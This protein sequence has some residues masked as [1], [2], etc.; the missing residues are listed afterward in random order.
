MVVLLI[1]N[2][3]PSMGYRYVQ[4]EESEEHM[5]GVTGV[6]NQEII[7]WEEAMSSTGI[8]ISYA[9][10]AGFS[11]RG[12]EVYKEGEEGAILSS[13]IDEDLE[14]G[15]ITVLDAG[16]KN[17]IYRIVFKGT[18][19]VD[20]VDT[21]V[22]E[23]IS[24]KVCSQSPEYQLTKS[25][26]TDV[27]KE[28]VTITYQAEKDMVYNKAYRTVYRV[29]AGGNKSVVEGK[30]GEITLEARGE[31]N[32]A[33]EETFSANEN[34]TIAYE[35]YY[36]L[37]DEMGQAVDST[38]KTMSFV[39]DKKAPEMRIQHNVS[40]S[41]LPQESVT[42]Q[43]TVQEDYYKTE[44]SFKFI[45]R[46]E[47]ID[48]TVDTKEHVF[49]QNHW[50]TTQAITFSEEGKYF[51]K[52]VAVDKA[53]NTVVTD[54]LEFIID[55]SAPV[56]TVTETGNGVD[57]I[58]Q[59]MTLD[60]DVFDI[61]GSDEDYEVKVNGRPARLTWV[62][63]QD[64]YTLSTS[65]TFGKRKDYSAET[66][67]EIVIKAKD[68]SNHEAAQVVKRFVIDYTAP[69]YTTVKV[70]S[71]KNNNATTVSLNQED[72]CYYISGNGR[73]SAIIH[74][75]NPGNGA[76]ASVE[77][78]KDGASFIQDTIPLDRKDTP[79]YTSVLFE[80]EG[81]YLA[82]IES[83]DVAGNRSSY[84]TKEMIVDHTAPV[85]DIKNV[86]GM[87]AVEVIENKVYG[88]G[89]KLRF[90]ATDKNHAPDQYMIRVE[91]RKGFQRDVYTYYGEDLN[92]KSSGDRIWTDKSFVEDGQYSITFYGK[93]KA[94]NGIIHTDYKKVSFVIDQTAPTIRQISDLISN[95]YYNTNKKFK[96]LVEES[97]YENAVVK[98]NV[99]RT[100]DGTVFTDVDKELS[101]ESAR[102]EFEYLCN[103]EG[104][105]RIS[106]RV[107]DT[108]GNEDTYQ[109]RFVIDKT[110]PELSIS[111]VQ[112]GGKTKEPVWL[113][114]GVKDRNHDF[115]SYKIMVTRTNRDGEEISRVIDDA[116]AWKNNGYEINQQN[117][118]LT[119]RGLGYK[120][121]GNY[122]VLFEGIDKA[123]N[124]AV[125]KRLTFTIDKTAP[126]I[127]DVTYTN[128][129]GVIEQ[130]YGNIYSNRT[131][132]LEF[133][134]W[135]SVAG[136][137]RNRIY[138]TI[139]DATEK[140]ELSRLFIARKGL[141]RSYYVYIPSDLGVRELDSKI[142]IWAN[143][144][145]G[146]ESHHVTNRIVYNTEKPQIHME[147]D[148]D[149]T[150]WVNQDVTFHTTVRDSK[151]GIQEITYSI[152]GEIVKQVTFD[153]VV[154]DYSYD[155]VATKNAD[156]VSGYAV[157]VEV[158]NN[159][160]LTAK[161]TRQV[162]IDKQAPKVELTGVTNE[163]HYNTNQT[164]HTKVS[165][166]SYKNTK[167][168]YYVT[169]TLDGVEH[170]VPLEDF[171]PQTYTDD[172]DH[173]MM[174]EGAY[175]MHAVTI[176]GAGNKT[177]SNELIFIIDKT[178]PKLS[179]TGVGSGSMNGSAVTLHFACEESFYETNQVSIQVEKTIDGATTTQ[180]LGGFPKNG[181]QSSMN[182]SFVLDGTYR[183]TFEARDKAGNVA[184]IQEVTF[185]VD[186]TIPEVDIRGTDNYEMWDEGATLQFV[187]TDSYYADNKVVI[188]GTRQDIDG[189]V[190]PVVVS[191]FVIT[192]K[193]STL[194]Q[195][196]SEDGIYTFVL[197][198]RDKAGNEQSKEIH[199][200]IDKTKPEIRGVSQYNG[201]YYQAFRLAQDLGEIFKDLTVISFK[202][203]L[204][205]IEYN[206]VDEIT[207]E[208]KYNL[209]V[210]V[211]DELGHINETNIEF[212]I[213]HT[214]PKIIFTGAPDGG[215]VY[216]A[217]T[218]TFALINSEDYITGIRINGTDYGTDLRSFDYTEYGSYHIEVDC[219]DEAGNKVTRTLYFVYNNPNVI[220]ILIGV[221][222]LFAICM[223]A[224]LIIQRKRRKGQS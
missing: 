188:E 160:G 136:V 200:T 53:G 203:F 129:N 23:T 170:T 192:G 31:Y 114:F 163:V 94:G 182:H 223:V 137:D 128:T 124:E 166:V 21:V 152:D 97:D 83:K 190:E 39:I 76:E 150:T 109:I 13:S 122:E 86:N 220:P 173:T 96:Y 143:D 207:E 189:H 11:K 16:D 65:I 85:F 102:Q 87:T 103:K 193:T 167:T 92:W 6:S 12:Y 139:G 222:G 63:G 64:E 71:V 158:T 41:N 59:D 204:N 100:L 219:C 224:F 22:E 2:L 171:V 210:E 121:E 34:E 106:V 82:T 52:A 35:I 48:G 130:K 181:K 185:S 120:E 50:Q 47:A 184:Q 79:Y 211:E 8:V 27:T 1:M 131:I 14:S 104:I 15:E 214:A 132:L 172:C 66:E 10:E 213:D 159:S 110:K 58:H 75:E 36:V 157:T 28:D 146:N 198:A 74:E 177:V 140:T 202:M 77:V 29:D 18:K 101:M 147:S 95:E 187:V 183:V 4:A 217:G 91:H 117:V 215:D 5:V 9:F 191:P 32:L 133:N 195:T 164:I 17:N 175:K 149:Y 45:V 54:I 19:E 169:R 127:S 46:K 40:S 62:K 201:G 115:S 161:A 60:I 84:T 107:K 135:D 134:V 180:E 69:A 119:E 7:T 89:L 138:V 26:D 20:G 51:V 37:K 156:K 70:E 176:D 199:F 197:S 178:A 90:Y 142:T 33:V 25:V 61:C 118:Y 151:S 88:A 49:G 99:Q 113:T 42:Y 209:Y 162:Y 56:V 73:L 43:V 98:L 123:T 216:E 111:G 221:F 68:Q 93:D 81:T 196:F 179:I 116:S 3:C 206:G 194:S 57:G 72:D 155:L 168:T 205:G 105:Y 67:Y 112:N 148:I 38:G 165:D 44:E 55:K 78:T 153:K 186:T 125:R 144:M 24:F 154:N 126:T 174:L 80:E 30:D 141:G 208:G 212:I 108:A 218:V 145:A